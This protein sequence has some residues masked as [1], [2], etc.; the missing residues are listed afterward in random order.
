MMLRPSEAYQCWHVMSK[1]I[2]NSIP[3]TDSWVTACYRKWK[4]AHNCN[5]S[6]FA[7]KIKQTKTHSYTN[8]KISK[9]YDGEIQDD[10]VCILVVR[11]LSLTRYNIVHTHHP[12]TRTGTLITHKTSHYT[13]PSRHD[14]K[15]EKISPT[16]HNKTLI[17]WH[18]LPCPPTGEMRATGACRN[19]SPISQRVVSVNHSS[20]SF[21]TSPLTGQEDVYIDETSLLSSEAYR[22]IEREL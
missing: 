16:S 1:T 21:I 20:Q 10:S 5:C 15:R 18:A 9:S 3:L 8:N 14:R 6:S 12:A 17:S 4:F 19:F 13:A 11:E 7:C 22:A 2:K